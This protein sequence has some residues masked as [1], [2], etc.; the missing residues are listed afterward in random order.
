MVGITGEGDATITIEKT[1]DAGEREEIPTII[2]ENMLTPYGYK[3]PDGVEEGLTYVDETT[4]GLEVY[5]TD[6]GLY[7]LGSEDGPV[8]FVYINDPALSMVGLGLWTGDRCA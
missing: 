6:D 8:L 3:L 2:Y 4:E 1:G 7:H 5:M